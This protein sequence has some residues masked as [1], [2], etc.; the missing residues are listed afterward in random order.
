M[1]SRHGGSGCCLYLYTLY[2]ASEV[3]KGR[4]EISD[5]GHERPEVYRLCMD[6]AVQRKYRL[7]KTD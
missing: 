5:I 2:A 1:L 7:A 6:G 3:L 4:G